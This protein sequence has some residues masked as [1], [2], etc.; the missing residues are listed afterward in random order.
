MAEA[1]EPEVTEPDELARMD[2]TPAVFANKVFAAAHP[3]GV[4]LTFAEAG[5]GLAS[6]RF[7]VFLQREVLADLRELIE[8][9]EQFD[10]QAE[11]AIRSMH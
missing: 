10:P 6:P 1:P 8:W 5:A 11:P 3:A 4:K 7:A 9:A 2:E